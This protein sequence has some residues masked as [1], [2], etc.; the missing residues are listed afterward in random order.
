MIEKI[1]CP[2]SGKPADKFPTIGDR[3]DIDSPSLGGR[4]SISD[5]AV[6]V[7]YPFS[8]AKRKHMEKLIKERRAAGDDCPLIREPDLQNIDDKDAA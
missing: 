2:V 5:S 8:D 6:A 3:L 1:T 4:Y 7:H